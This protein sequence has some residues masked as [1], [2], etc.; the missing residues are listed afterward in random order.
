MF[1]FE[2]LEYIVAMNEEYR[3]NVQ[4]A[5][6][7]SLLSGWIHALVE[8]ISKKIT[9]TSDTLK[10]LAMVLC[11]AATANVHNTRTVRFCGKHVAIRAEAM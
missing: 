1:E 8:G 3:T 11:R 6:A 10:R 7:K 2:G 4:G 9:P 5:I